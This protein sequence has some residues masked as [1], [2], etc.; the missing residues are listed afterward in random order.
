MGKEKKKICSN[1]NGNGF[2]KIDE[3]WTNVRQCWICK[4]KGEI[5]INEDKSKEGKIYDTRN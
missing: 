5:Y 3:S 2:I 4:S 1:C